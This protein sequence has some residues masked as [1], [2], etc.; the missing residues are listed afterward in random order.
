M[1]SGACSLI[2]EAS[3][4][5]DQYNHEDRTRKVS[6]VRLI[7]IVANVNIRTSDDRLIDISVVR[8]PLGSL[9]YVAHAQRVTSHA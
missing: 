6:G 3:S 7:P 5:N 8:Q 9:R 2:T 1:A 4:A